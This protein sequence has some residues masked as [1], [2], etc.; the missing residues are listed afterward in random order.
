MLKVNEI[1][2]SI[3]GE[4]SYAGFPCVFIRL[5]GCNLRCSYC[6]T[7]YAYKEGT[8][9]LVR[10]IVKAVSLH[11]IPLVEIT[12][13]E[14]LDQEET[15]LLAESL[16]DT[17][18]SVLVETNGTKDISL[19]PAGVTRIMDIKCPGSGEQGKTDWGNMDRLSADDEVKFVICGEADYIWAREVLK[20]YGLAGKSKV[21][22]SPAHGRLQSSDLAG[23]ILRDRLPVRLQLQLH[24]ILWPESGRAK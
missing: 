2:Q 24:Q 10:D 5:S 12:G 15:P 11:E 6:D 1:F 8:L 23:W 4:S 9:W 16:L 22:F 3:Q 13:G 18:Y 17:G 14:P 21:L 19:L 7:A 20:K